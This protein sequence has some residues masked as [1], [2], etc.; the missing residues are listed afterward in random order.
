MPADPRSCAPS[1]PARS[2]RPYARASRGG[3]RA[4]RSG[5]DVGGRGP[6]EGTYPCRIGSEL[7]DRTDEGRE[8]PGSTSTPSDGPRQPRDTADAKCDHAAASGHRFEEGV[9]QALVM[10]WHDQDIDVRQESC[11][12]TDGSTPRQ[13]AARGEGPQAFSNHARS[14]PSPAIV[15]VA[16]VFSSRRRRATSRSSCVPF[17][18]LS[19]P[20]Y[21]TRTGPRPGLSRRGHGSESSSSASPSPLSMTTV[22]PTGLPALTRRRRVSAHT[23]ITLVAGARRQ[24]D[25]AI[26]RVPSG[27]EPQQPVDRRDES[28]ARHGKRAASD[29]KLP[30]RPLT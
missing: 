14:G 18:G 24:I 12:V 30:R 10:G 2:S 21:P 16:D 29:T 11:S 20:R 6:P 5:P 3:D 17:S 1:P 15:S 23:A 7:V 26:E 13:T 9:R 28:K 22:L 25:D 19:R 27:V 4:A 8:S